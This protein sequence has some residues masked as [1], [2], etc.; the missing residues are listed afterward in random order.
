MG[1]LE[2]WHIAFFEERYEHHPSDKP[3]DMSPKSNPGF[4]CT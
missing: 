1:W 2:E 4:A 3:T